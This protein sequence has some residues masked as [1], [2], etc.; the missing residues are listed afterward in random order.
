MGK[1][2]VF[3]RLGGCNFT[4][5]G[6]G[7]RALKNG[8]EYIGCD[9]IYAANGAFS[10]EWQR[11]DH[12]GIVQKIADVSFQNKMG[13]FDIILTG[14][15]PTLSFK[16]PVLQELL[17]TFSSHQIWV[18]SNASVLFPFT[19][20]LK[21]LHFTLSIK[22]AY[23]LESAKKRINFEAIANILQNARE[24]VFK[25][26]I[27]DDILACE[28]EIL[29]ILDFAK[30]YGKFQVFIMPLGSS[31]NEIDTKIPDMLNLCLKHGWS[32]SDRL[33]IRIFGDKRG[34]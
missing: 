13:D 10:D 16:I 7:N 20:R 33:H 12:K 19:P 27:N 15:E 18:E 34:V 8:I 17:G 29:Q 9:S 24:V 6:F 30:K 25:F 32:L 28:K 14:G 5:A 23:S 4:C 26:V 22:L 1:P 11:L 31:T 3:V 21:N 2:S